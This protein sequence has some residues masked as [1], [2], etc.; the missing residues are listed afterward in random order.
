MLIHTSCFL[1]LAQNWSSQ[2]S[3]RLFLIRNLSRRYESL[4]IIFQITKIFSKMTIN[5]FDFSG[6]LLR[7]ELSCFQLA[8]LHKITKCKWMSHDYKFLHYGRGGSSIPH[9]QQQKWSKIH[10]AIAI[11]VYFLPSRIL[12]SSGSDHATYS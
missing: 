1:T 12:W 7:S 9:R 5:D 4:S 3:R 2:M 6:C 10:S 11:T 8:L